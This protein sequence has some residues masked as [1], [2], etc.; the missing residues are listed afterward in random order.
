MNNFSILSGEKFSIVAIP[1]AVR[2][3]SDTQFPLHLADDLWAVT[4]LPVSLAEHWK[5]WIG[6]I[7]AGDIERASLLLVAKRRS[8][9]PRV[10]DGDTKAL[11][12]RIRHLYWGAL[13]VAPLVCSKAPTLVLGGCHD[14]SCDVHQVALLAQPYY[15]MGTDT[16]PVSQ[17]W[18]VESAAIAD[19][20]DK[21]PVGSFKRI[22]RA[23]NAF[24]TAI[25]TNDVAERLHQFARCVD[26]F[27][28]GGTANRFASR[29]ELFVGTGHRERMGDIYKL[30]SQIEHLNDLDPSL[31]GRTD[32]DRRIAFF[33]SLLVVENVAR[34]C[35]RRFL[36]D[37]RLWP[38]FVDQASIK[39]FWEDGRE[40]VRTSEWG[41]LF[42]LA[43]YLTKIDDLEIPE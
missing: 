16:V 5:E 14:E 25:T 9:S 39:A 7:R 23:F 29:T 30:R 40:S 22:N 38:H 2:E 19:A 36:A 8:E 41:S 11:D 3:S 17:E 10:Q 33:K 24:F 26:G 15:T 31:P 28:Q 43:A 35:V 34:H 12:R 1:G 20:L 18:L 37:Q 32:R 21:M 42:D 13:A 6:S 27:I 4:K